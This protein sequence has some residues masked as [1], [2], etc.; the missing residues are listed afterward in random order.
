M[1]SK[2]TDHYFELHE[3]Y[4]KEFG[5]DNTLVLYQKGE[6]YE[7]YGIE[8]ENVSRGPNMQQ[9]SNILDYKLGSSNN[10]KEHSED[11]P[12][13]IGI[14]IKP[15][16]IP[17]RLEQLCEAG[18]TCILVNERKSNGRIT[19]EVDSI[20]SIGTNIDTLS[21]DSN[22]LC[23]VYLHI[24]SNSIG[25]SGKE[26]QLISI[27][28]SVIDVSTGK[29][30][31][32]EI[33][34]GNTSN[35]EINYVFDELYR[36]IFSFLPKE[37][38]CYIEY[39][40]S[41]VKEEE[42]NYEND[43]YLKEIR[44]RLNDI[45]YS[46]NHKIYVNKVKKCYKDINYQNKYLDEIYNQTLTDED[47]IVD[48]DITYI[49]YFELNGKNN[50]IISLILLLQFANLHNPLIIK[51]VNIPIVLEDSKN[52]VLDYN[53]ISQLD[54]IQSESSKLDKK[55]NSVCDIEND[56]CTKRYKCLFDVI[57][58]TRTSMGKR[59]LKENILNPS[60]DHD[61]LQKCY[62]NIE[63]LITKL[64][65]EQLKRLG[66]DISN[67]LDIERLQRKL[68]IEQI[69]CYEL[70]NFYSS[71]HS[72]LLII[73]SYKDILKFTS[74]LND[75]DNNND[76]DSKLEEEIK[77]FTNK[78]EKI[79]NLNVLEKY[80]YNTKNSSSTSDL[81]FKSFINKGINTDIDEYIKNITNIE[82]E[83]D[84]LKNK[85]Q[86]LIPVSNKC[87]KESITLVR[88]DI[89]YL[90]LTKK[91]FEI[92]KKN[93][94]S[95]QDNEFNLLS[96]TKQEVRITNNK[97]NKMYYSMKSYQDK[98]LVSLSEMYS[99][100][101]TYF[102]EKFIDLFNNTLEFI[103]NLDVIY[104]NT[105]TAL[106]F[107]YSKPSIIPINDTSN[108]SEGESRSNER[109]YISIKGMRHPLIERIITNENY[110][111]IDVTIGKEDCKGILLYGVNA[112]GKSSCMKAIGVNVIMAQ[113]GMYVPCES[114]ELKLFSKLMTR[115]TGTDDLLRG[116]SSFVVEMSELRSI[117][118]RSNKNTLVLGDE[119][120]RGTEQKSGLAIIASTIDYLIRNND[121]NFIFATHAHGLN[122]MDVIEQLK[123]NVKQFHMRVEK[124]EDGTLIYHRTLHE[125]C[126]DTIYG[127]LVT[128]SL[129]FPVE[130]ISKAG[131]LLREINEEEEDIY[132]IKNSRY[133]KNVYMA[134][135]ELCGKKAE[136]THHLLQQKDSNC[137]KMIGHVEKDH[138]ANLVTLCKKCHIKLHINGDK[139]KWMK[140]NKGYKLIKVDK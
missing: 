21:L 86:D 41:K 20:I 93:I 97:L 71:Y 120:C 13:L 17:L 76:N 138:K 57:C 44:K 42:E 91:R 8:L 11:N 103:I 10:S 105:I 89:I 82:K 75:N 43:S 12:Y 40:Q 84:I 23:S 59:R 32:K 48:K 1:R 9:I 60:C 63:V 37:I 113:A 52:L 73:S 74:L 70:F 95:T 100:I 25:R 135:C 134:K 99:Q 35:G 101:I 14:P 81:K 34:N 88:E 72:I 22:Y 4:I 124:L 83:I 6:F 121:T 130:F 55:I 119:I 139:Y 111:P 56:T 96:S 54:I 31:I 28:M 90:K 49:E 3:K 18:Y 15:L 39:S 92:L 136:D 33:S 126:G 87:V 19:R 68:I 67:V 66:K 107:N 122:E 53:T 30:S 106:K 104:S 50:S 140:T 137:W 24:W 127:L 7:M 109:S 47:S 46:I 108:Q 26:K 38:I 116:K 133:N 112:V 128:E 61:Y 65:K 2:M 131:R 110:V 85:Y 98:L 36:F 118:Y 80:D 77:V 51:R 79:F 114:M 45:F 69:N 5:K 78:F 94:K 132:S 58:N 64:D 117:I 129:G 125:G 102:R 123:D 62:N 27:G 16:T 29:I 115:I